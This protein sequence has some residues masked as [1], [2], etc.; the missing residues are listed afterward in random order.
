[1]S[2]NSTISHIISYSIPGYIAERENTE[3]LASYSDYFD[4]DPI[5]IWK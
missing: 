4:T 2:T 3:P 5:W 1:M